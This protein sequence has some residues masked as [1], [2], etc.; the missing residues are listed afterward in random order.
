MSAINLADYDIASKIWIYLL[1]IRQKRFYTFW[2]DLSSV[3]S[4][5]CRSA[6]GIVAIGHVAI[7]QAFLSVSEPIDSEMT[8]DIGYQQKVLQL[9]R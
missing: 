4:L 2:N 5:Y 1:I 3:W 6:M 9:V 7:G 8:A